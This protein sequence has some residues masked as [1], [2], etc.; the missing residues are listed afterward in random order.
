MLVANGHVY[1][2]IEDA[3]SGN[4]YAQPNFLFENRGAKFSLLLPGPADSLGSTQVSRG[5][6]LGDFDNDGAL[7]IFITNLNAAPVLLRNNLPGG[8]N[9]LGLRLRATQ[10][11]SCLLYTSDAADE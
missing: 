8:K 11:N 10:G 7:D 5:A 2:Q 6:A 4:T 3:G 1:P 9:W